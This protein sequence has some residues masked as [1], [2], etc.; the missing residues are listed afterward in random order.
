MATTVTLGTRVAPELRDQVD[1]LAKALRRDRAW[2]LEEALKRY[3]AEESQF[4]AAI[5]QGKADARAGRVTEHNA[6]M[7]ELDTL[8]DQNAAH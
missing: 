2:I 1:T 4:L 7:A 3:I 8:I 6:F 5:E